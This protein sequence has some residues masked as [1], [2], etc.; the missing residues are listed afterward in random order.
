MRR[1]NTA[2]VSGVVQPGRKIERL[3]S[4]QFCCLLRL[5]LTFIVIGWSCCA[6]TRIDLSSQS[7]RID[8]SAADST[9]PMKT[10][11]ALPETCAAGEVF[12]LLSATAG[13]NVYTCL[14]TN[15]WTVQNAAIP[16]STTAGSVLSTKSDG[17]FQ[18]IAVPTVADLA[19]KAPVSHTNAGAEL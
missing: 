17:T 1:S 11:A 9:K 7:K 12:L 10:G 4:G 18:W 14:A 16:Q 3:F 13:S 19:T 8:F 2:G 6:Q 15:I 5:A